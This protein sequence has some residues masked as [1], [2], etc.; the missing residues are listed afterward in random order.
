MKKLLTMLGIISMIG[1]TASVVVACKNPKDKTED[2]NKESDKKPDKEPDKD[3]GDKNKEPNNGNNNKPNNNKKIN[4]KIKEV[5]KT[6][7]DNK[8]LELPKEIKLNESKPVEFKVIEKSLVDFLVNQKISN[9]DQTK[10]EIKNFSDLVVNPTITKDKITN[11]HV[12]VAVSYDKQNVNN[13]KDNDNVFK[14]EFGTAFTNGAQQI[15]DKLAAGA[16]LKL[17]QIT[18]PIDIPIPGLTTL[19]GIFELLYGMGPGLFAGLPNIIPESKTD[20]NWTKWETFITGLES[21][22]G[23][24]V[25]DFKLDG[26]Y[27]KEIVPIVMGPAELSGGIHLKYRDVLNALLPTLINFKNYVNHQKTQSIDNFL[28]L[29]INYLFSE[30]KSYDDGYEDINPDLH[31]NHDATKAKFKFTNNLEVM[32]NNLLEGWVTKSKEHSSEEQ[33][34]QIGLVATVDL[35]KLGNTGGGLLGGLGGLLGNKPLQINLDFKYQ[36]D[37]NGDNNF[38]G[39]K[40]ILPMKSIEELILQLFNFDSTK[41]PELILPGI[42]GLPITIPPIALPLDKLITGENLFSLLES[43]GLDAKAK[44]SV[45]LKWDH[46]NIEVLGLNSKKEWIPIKSIEELQTVKD[47]KIKL[48]NKIILEDKNSELKIELDNKEIDFILDLKS[49]FF[50]TN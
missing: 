46:L 30:P 6:L 47:I 13:T 1:S 38:T 26:T 22:I 9:F 31:I 45:A 25:K 48:K 11:G 4:Q 43:M 14:I 49:D 34:I 50:I 28:M 41:N 5:L 40:D 35:S 23:M 32:L 2:K 42:A 8:A 10:L 24:L 27:D 39:L 17:S 7:V 21:L 18:S 15:I 44:D 20:D 16:E 33:P 29:F 37:T 19:G 36:M 3:V 12:T